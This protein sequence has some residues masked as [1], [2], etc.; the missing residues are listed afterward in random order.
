[1]RVARQSDYAKP[2]SP[3]FVATLAAVIDG[4]SGMK[5]IADRA[6]GIS[7]ETVKNN[8]AI[9]REEN[10]IEARYGEKGRVEYRLPV[11]R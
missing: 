7:A 9:L 5:E 4:W 8:L 6:K 2:R 3:S 11:P 1:M 10:A